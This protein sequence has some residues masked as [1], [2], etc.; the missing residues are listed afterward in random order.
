M[1]QPSY[2]LRVRLAAPLACNIFHS[3]FICDLRHTNMSI[4]LSNL[5]ENQMLFLTEVIGR[6]LPTWEAECDVLRGY[7][8]QILNLGIIPN[9]AEFPTRP[10]E[11]NQ[12]PG[13][14]LA[15]AENVREVLPS[16]V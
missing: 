8:T 12:G 5:K 7:G 13:L 11:A 6:V 14:T 1:G 2:F 15:I 9:T 4:R 16:L 10:Y 3:C